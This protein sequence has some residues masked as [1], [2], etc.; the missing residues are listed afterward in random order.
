MNEIYKRFSCNQ[1]H[2][3]KISI[4]LVEALLKAGMHA[5]S[6]ANQQPWEFVV[7]DKRE[8]LDE[9][10]RVS[11]Y[12]CALS[13]APLAIVVLSKGDKDLKIP[14]CKVQDL[15]ACTQNIL[16]QATALDLASLWIPVEPFEIRKEYMKKLLRLPYDM[17]AFSVICVGYADVPSKRPSRFDRE[18]I[19]FN[20]YKF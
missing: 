5:P 6:S 11:D 19:F 12:T 17:D 9:L 3:R 13:T 10:A 1:F 15:S 4:D 7:I 14:Y 8:I 20:E 18:R 2:D 16:L